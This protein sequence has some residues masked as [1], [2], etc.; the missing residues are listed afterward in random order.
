M[1]NGAGKFSPFPKMHLYFYSRCSGNDMGKIYVEIQGCQ[2]TPLPLPWGAH[3]RYHFTTASGLRLSLGPQTKVWA[4]SQARILVPISI[5]RV[6]QKRDHTLVT[7]IL[8][9]LNRFTNFFSLKDSLVNL[10]LNAY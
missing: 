8:S 6:G 4:G 10:Q 2:V 1:S 5:Y 9:N 3:V 7:I